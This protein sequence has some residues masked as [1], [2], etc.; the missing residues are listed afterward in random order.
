MVVVIMPKRSYLSRYLRTN[1][2]LLIKSVRLVLPL[3]IQVLFV[4]LSIYFT[5][6]YRGI[7][8]TTTNIYYLIAFYSYTSLFLLNYTCSRLY[9]EGVRSTYLTIPTP[10]RLKYDFIKNFILILPVTLTLSVYGK[11]FGTELLL[12]LAGLLL[13]GNSL[14]Y[15]IVHEHAIY[16]MSDKLGAMFVIKEAT[17]GRI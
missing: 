5:T 10:Y 9:Y 12:V 2:Y 13:F 7:E 17:D 14:L 1:G 8:F 3:V 11:F 4:L 16:R 15:R 6:V